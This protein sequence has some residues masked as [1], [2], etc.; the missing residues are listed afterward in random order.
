MVYF[1]WDEYNVTLSKSTMKRGLAWIKR[2]KK[3]ISLVFC[4]R[5][6]RFRCASMNAIRSLEAN[7][8][9][10]LQTIQH[11]NFSSLMNQPQTSVLGTEN[12]AGPLLVSPLSNIRPLRGQN[13][14]PFCQSIALMASW[15]GRS[16]REAGQRRH[17]MILSVHRSC[18]F[19]SRIRARALFWSWIMPKSTIQRCAHLPYIQVNILGACGDVQGGWDQVGVLATIFARFQPD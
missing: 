10:R 19:V 12:M 9:A 2:T 7:G 13:A 17:S 15:S 11:H 8:F 4:K 3:R 6:D 16:F 14:G 1:I 18:Q 5:D